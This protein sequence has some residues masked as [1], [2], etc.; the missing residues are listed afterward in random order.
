MLTTWNSFPAINTLFDDVLARDWP[1]M[2]V[3]RS[4]SSDV[5]VRYD[6]EAVYLVM[7]VPGVRPE[8]LDVHID[9]GVLSIKGE[10]KAQ[11]LGQDDEAASARNTRYNKSFRLPEGLDTESV[12]AKLEYGVLHVRL[13]KRPEIQPK[14]IPVSVSAQAE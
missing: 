14:R 13:A 12:D 7:D 5:E 2:R 3:E 1:S 8:D 4:W 6:D 11:S 9:K 10:R